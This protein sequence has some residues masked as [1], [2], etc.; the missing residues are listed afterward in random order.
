MEQMSSLDVTSLRSAPFRSVVGCLHVLQVCVLYVLGKPLL[1]R[2]NRKVRGM[3]LF[4]SR[5]LF[6]LV[7][8]E[9]WQS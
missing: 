2:S 7:D 3:N 1:T 4:E 5:Q 8:T 9:L 6:T